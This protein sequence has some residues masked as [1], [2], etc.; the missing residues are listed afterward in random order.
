[1]AKISGNKTIAKELVDL[2]ITKYINIIFKPFVRKTLNEQE[3][4]QLLHILKLI[5]N[6]SVLGE[7]VANEYILAKDSKI[8]ALEDIKEQIGVKSY[9]LT[10][11]LI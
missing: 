6:T 10:Q 3:T 8:S 5:Q 9:F 7:E 2:G 4:Y 11:F 1:L